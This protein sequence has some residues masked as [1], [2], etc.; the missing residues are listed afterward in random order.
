M[1]CASSPAR[2]YLVVEY[3]E[4]ASG[5]W[6][7]FRAS[8][9]MQ[10]QRHPLSTLFQVN[11]LCALLQVRDKLLM[12]ILRRDEGLRTDVVHPKLSNCPV[13]NL[14]LLTDKVYQSDSRYEN[15]FT[16]TSLQQRL[17]NKQNTGLQ[18]SPE[19]PV[20]QTRCLGVPGEIRQS[21]NASPM[22]VSTRFF[23]VFS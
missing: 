9:F 1:L 14:P 2:I 13:I 8:R 5:T 16:T 22:A 10:S 21:E 4:S 3:T 15:P 20:G 6:L 11:S 23:E 19:A 7:S 17:C 18:L 12:H